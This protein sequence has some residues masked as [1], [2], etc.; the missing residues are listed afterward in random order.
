MILKITSRSRTPSGLP[1]GMLDMIKDIVPGQNR[2]IRKARRDRSRKELHKRQI[3]K[4]SK[5]KNRRKK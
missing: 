4:A 2:A 1:S 5:R 3:A